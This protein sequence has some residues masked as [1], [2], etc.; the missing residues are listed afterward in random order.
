MT[1]ILNTPLPLGERE[2]PKLKAWEGEGKRRLFDAVRSHLH[3]ALILPLLAQSAPP[4]ALK[5]EGL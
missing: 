1:A 4:S 3:R 2:G 5:G